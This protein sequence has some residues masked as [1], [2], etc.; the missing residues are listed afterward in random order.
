MITVKEFEIV[1]SVPGFGELPVVWRCWLDRNAYLERYELTGDVSQLVELGIPLLRSFK[2]SEIQWSEALAKLLNTLPKGSSAVRSYDSM[3]EVD[4]K[5]TQAIVEVTFSPSPYEW[6]GEAHFDL[7]GSLK[8]ELENGRYEF[9]DTTSPDI[10]IRQLGVRGFRLHCC[11][12]CV[13]FDQCCYGGTDKWEGNYCFVKSAVMDKI[14]RWDTGQIN[15]DEDWDMFPA[16]ADKV[17]VS[18]FFVCESWEPF[19]PSRKK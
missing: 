15:K 10:A 5:T 2:Q 18:P 13:W 11:A 3:V 1:L 16:L 4:G 9:A 6:Q 14:A 19:K 7:R 12:T 8:V 17:L